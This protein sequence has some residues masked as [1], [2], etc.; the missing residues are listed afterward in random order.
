MR[1]APLDDVRR[2]FGVVADP[3]GEGRFTIGPLANARQF[4]KVQGMI[5]DGMKEATLIAGGIGRPEGFNKGYFTRPT[6]F[7]SDTNDTTIA[8]EEIFG[9]VLTIRLCPVGKP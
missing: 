4:D 2:L 8:R 3:A 5:A 7:V 9:P 6:V 1:L